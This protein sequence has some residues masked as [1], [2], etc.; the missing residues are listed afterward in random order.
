MTTVKKVLVKPTREQLMNDLVTMK[1]DQE[2]AN[3]YGTSRV[4]LTKWKKE[5]GLFKG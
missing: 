1:N 5:L 4:T 3:K 2:I